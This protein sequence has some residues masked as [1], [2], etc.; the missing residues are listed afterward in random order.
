MSVPPRPVLG[1]L[2]RRLGDY[3]KGGSRLKRE[4]FIR[5]TFVLPRADARRRAREYY[6][7]WPSEAYWTAVDSWC[8]RPGDEIEFTMR[9]LESAD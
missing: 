1:T 5:E 3:R 8:E 9:R 2:K 4:G 7:Q 6:R